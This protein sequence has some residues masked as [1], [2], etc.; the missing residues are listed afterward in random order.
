[1]PLLITL[2]VICPIMYLSH[3]SPLLRISENLNFINSVYVMVITQRDFHS[4]PFSGFMHT[5]SQ[6]S[7]LL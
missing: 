2:P 6:K 3:N 5:P 1:M 4:N 7:P